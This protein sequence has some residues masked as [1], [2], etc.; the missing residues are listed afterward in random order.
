EKLAPAIAELKR[1]REDAITKAKADLATYDEMTKT[2]KAELEK[3]R[4][5]EIAVRQS[6]LKDH[7]KL[8]PAETSFW[9]RKNN[10]AEPKTVWVPVDLQEFSATNDTKLTRQADGSILTS[11][12]KSPSEFLILARSP[13]TN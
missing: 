5:S 8:L 9:E 2:L 4:Q 3:R 10:P 12:G 6:A 7:E 1:Q 13:L 11:G